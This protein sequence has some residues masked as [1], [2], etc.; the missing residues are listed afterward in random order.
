M[1]F[2]VKKDNGYALLA[3]HYNMCDANVCIELD[4]ICN[5][6]FL[7]YVTLL[8]LGQFPRQDNV[9][10]FTRLGPGAGFKGKVDMVKK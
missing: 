10:K 9:W 8:F 2:D 3:L 6:T 4:T 1:K 5:P 7:L